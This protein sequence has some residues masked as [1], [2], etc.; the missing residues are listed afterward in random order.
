VDDH[1][2]P[3]GE[4]NGQ[5]E[6]NSQHEEV[7]SQTSMELGGASQYRPIILKTYAFHPYKMKV[8]QS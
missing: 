5:S 7:N 4:G 2:F 6:G 3:R 1:P 8:L